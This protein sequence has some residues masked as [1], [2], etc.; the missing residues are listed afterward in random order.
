MSVLPSEAI[1]EWNRLVKQIAE[2]DYAYYVLDEP[3]VSDVD[4]D[5]CM[6][7]LKQLEADYPSLQSPQSPSQRVAGSIQAKFAS[8][9]HRLGMYSLDNAFSDEDV[10][11]FWQR[12]HSLAPQAQPSFCAEPKLDGL[13]INLTYENG[14]LT[15]ATTRGDG[16]SGEVVT[17]NIR[18]LHN[19]PLVFRTHSPKGVIEVR[20]EVVMSKRAFQALNERQVAQGQKPFANPRNAAAGS[21]RQL[22]ARI[23]AER[24][25]QFFAYA[26]GFVEDVSILA[27]TQ[28]GVL[29]QLH[30]WGFQVAKE[31]SHLSGV[32]AL[33]AYYEHIQQQRD[34]LAYDI[35]G[36]VYKLDDRAL[37]QQLGMT[38]K[39]PRWAIAHKFP[40]QEVWTTLEAIDIQ[41]GRSGALTPVA[42]LTPVSVGGVMV[43]NAT[44]HNADEIARKDVRVGDTLVVRRAGDVIPEVVAVVA[45]LRPDHTTPFVM[46]T[47]CPVCQSAVV[48]ESDKS[49]HRCSG[50]LYCPAQKQRALEHFVSRKAMDI[51]GLGGKVIEQLMASG[52]VAHA[53]DLYR[54]SLLQLINLDRMGEKSARNLLVSIDESKNTTLARFIYAL[55]IPEVGEVTAKSLAQHFGEL[56]PLMQADEVSLMQ[57]RD[58]GS[59]VAKAIVQFF[60]QPHN[61]EVIEQLRLLGVHWL[62]AEKVD[63]AI[64]SAVM[65]KIVV[66]TGT[67]SQLSREEA[68][69]ILEQLGAKVTGSVSAKTDL[70]IAGEAAG[71]KLV[72]A[73]Q[74]GVEVWDEA[75]FIARCISPLKDQA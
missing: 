8:Q 51:Q 26:V 32:H 42:R 45:H 25:L 40:A 60:A 10:M 47:E 68:K 44:L 24:Q 52:L 49:V 4:Y 39:F 46:P 2:Y 7:Q 20:G 75:S 33:L 11:A 12:I 34:Q 41:V 73:E 62:P 6:A 22:D 21:L 17:A 9:Q 19:V 56:A 69:A 35:D 54:L 65:N 59:V 74:L 29:K 72:K 63:G 30:Q 71:S 61:R 16:V 3:G 14:C 57:I 53:D 43:S 37:Q 36:V 67:L 27:A 31:V 15:H 48:Q 23:T 1:A 55:G 70:L 50:G 64:G 28:T 38:A 66:L 13:A 18:T 58:V 5:Q